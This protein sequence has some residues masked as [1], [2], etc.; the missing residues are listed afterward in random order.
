MTQAVTGCGFVLSR[1]TLKQRQSDIVELWLATDNG[2]LCLHSEAQPSVCFIKV[3]DEGAVQHL[4]Q[5]DNLAIAIEPTALKTLEQDSTLLLRARN[6]HQLLQFRRLAQTNH[7]TVYEADIRLADRF[8]MERFAYGSLAFRGNPA[9]V[10]GLLKDA[11]IKGIEYQP[12]LSALSF[13]IECDEHENLFSIA[14][15]SPA[16][17]KV[18]VVKH[19]EHPQVR[20]PETSSFEL[21]WA[22]DERALLQH[23]VAAIN[24]A[25]PDILLGWNVKQF[26]LAVLARRAQK[27]GMPLAMGRHQHVLSV[28]EWEAGQVIAEIP[29]RCVIDGIEALKTMTYQFDS[30]ALDNVAQNL[31]STGKLIE[32]EDR[33][34]AIKALYLSDPVGLAKYNFQDCVLVNAIAEK[35]RF[36]DFL[37]LRSTLT[38]LDMS[39]PGGSVAAFVNVYLP[40]LHRGGYISGVRPEHGGLASPGG[41]VMNSRPGLYEHV[42]VLDFKSLYPSIIR[43]FKIDPMGLAEGLLHPDAAIEGFKG[44]K[45]SRDKHYLPDIIAN[46]WSQRDE[47]KKQ[48]DAARSQAIKILMNSFYGVLGSGGCPFYDP[49]LA[50]SITMRGHEIM[51][52]TARWIEEQGYDVIYGDTDSTFVHVPQANTNEQARNIGKT[53]EAHINARWQAKLEQ[54]FN[55]P[56]FLEIEFETHF[57][58]FFM[59]T[60]RGSELGSKKRYAG[61]ITTTDEPKLVFKG[62]E[63]VR[64]DWTQL[65]K[66][67]QETLYWK[68]FQDQP[69]D[70]YIRDILATVRAG[71]CDE[72]LVYT[73]RL[74][75]PLRQYTKSMPPHVKAAQLADE[76]NAKAGKPLQYQQR[77]RVRYVITTQGPQP[78][79]YQS[80]PL[81]YDHYIEKQIRPIADSLL[82]TVGMTFDA[83]DNQQLGLF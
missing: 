82:P 41:Y 22:D 70:Q 73:K 31:L 50:S 23:F 25:D 53:L 43:T 29:G 27:L 26:D 67:F 45:F 9:N 65:A 15:D 19:R 58:R 4:I 51:Q 55:L 37:M 20:S 47:A 14:L 16:C 64:S 8:L 2:P 39:R 54:D 63:T 1:R 68:V 80:A 35:T 81:D 75:K 69:V 10:Q 78:L 30:F 72:D 49:R 44:A 42:L 52:T 36:I 7:I 12:T 28:R 13:D 62:L 59:P 3:E 83:L 24:Q 33:L 5:S 21:I 79:E 38:G 61:L 56:C 6:E 57:S 60:I 11:Q 18:I 34:E 46:L 66:Q 32:D 74:R 48:K 71:E 40:R 77:T 76:L 17:K